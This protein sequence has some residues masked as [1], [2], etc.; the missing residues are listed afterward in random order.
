[1]IKKKILILSDYFIPGYM[2]GGPIQSLYNFCLRFQDEFEFSVITRGRDLHQETQYESINIDEWNYNPVLKCNIYYCS[3]SKENI[4]S[5]YKIIESRTFNTIYL[6]SFFSPIFSFP[7]LLFFLRNKNKFK[8]IIAPRGELNLGA[9]NVKRLKKR[10]F[11]FLLKQTG[12]FN[13]INWQATSIDEI[14]RINIMLGRK[15]P[16]FLMENIPNQIQRKWKYKHKEKGEVIFYTVSRVSEIKNIHFFIDL[17]KGFSGKISFYIIGPIEDKIYHDKCLKT[18]QGLS[19]NIK[20]EFLKEMSGSLIR[21]KVANYDFFVSPTL[22]E[23]FGHSIFEALLAGKPL[24]ISDRTPWKELKEKDL[25]FDITLEN[26]DFWKL[27]IQEAIEINSTRYNRLSQNAW[28]YSKEY[29]V[30]D[31]NNFLDLSEVF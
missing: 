22:G 26:S 3:K 7:A 1:M 27:A 8:L 19:S 18:I 13:H 12:I 20:V 24:I 29:L 16:S 10:I 25:G 15:M 5:I 14:K 31:N 11:L 4:L 2:A 9:L 28:N 21:E 30:K 17:L 6:N 23:N